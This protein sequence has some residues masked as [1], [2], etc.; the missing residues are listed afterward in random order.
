MQ[1]RLIF[2]DSEKNINLIKSKLLKKYKKFEN[3]ST[4]IQ[5]LQCNNPDKI[6]EYMVWQTILSYEKDLEILK[7]LPT[8]SSIE[9]RLNYRDEIIIYSSDFFQVFT[10]RRIEMLEYISKHNPISLKTLAESMD[11]DYKNVYDDALALERFNLIEFIRK[12]KNKR[13]VAR[14]TAI[15]ITFK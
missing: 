4:D 5:Q 9:Q 8:T 7:H 1:T 13:P 3:L 11:R 15:E 6:D 2:S 14:I 12:G 10:P